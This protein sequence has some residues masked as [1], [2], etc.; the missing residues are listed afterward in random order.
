MSRAGKKQRAFGK[1]GGKR[2]F[3]DHDQATAALRTI[4]TYGEQREKNPQRAY[5][6]PVCNGWHLT[7]RPE[8]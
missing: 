4:R 8:R 1:C 2:R 6:C 5:H 3:R 7:S